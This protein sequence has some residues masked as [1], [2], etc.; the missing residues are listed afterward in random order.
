[1]YTYLHTNI[2][3]FSEIIHIQN[4]IEN[5]ILSAIKCNCLVFLEMK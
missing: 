4:R 2:L 1:M 3:H 5:C